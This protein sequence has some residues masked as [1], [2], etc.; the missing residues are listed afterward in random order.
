MIFTF[1]YNLSSLKVFLFNKGKY[2]QRP[3]FLFPQK[4]VFFLRNKYN[5]LVYDI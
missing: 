3:L 2:R 5:L 1:L 4:K